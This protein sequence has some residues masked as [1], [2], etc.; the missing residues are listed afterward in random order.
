MVRATSNIVRTFDDQVGLIQQA[1]AR[2]QQQ[3][4]VAKQMSYSDFLR[5]SGDL[6]LVSNLPITIVEFGDIYL[7]VTSFTNFSTS[8]R[9]IDF[10]EFFEVVLVIVI[11][12]VLYLMYQ[13]L[14]NANCKI[15]ITIIFHALLLS[16]FCARSNTGHRA[17]RTGRLQAPAR[18]SEQRR[19]G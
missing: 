8:L 1:N 5:F 14:R 11:R 6:G 3:S 9:K 19:Q 12:I 7:T 17:H 16:S 18:H 15:T 2:C 4:A 13:L 10:N